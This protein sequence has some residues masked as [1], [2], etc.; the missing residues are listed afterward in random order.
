ME[1]IQVGSDMAMPTLSYVAK[2]GLAVVIG[3]IISGISML[4]VHRKR[5]AMIRCGK[6]PNAPH[7]KPAYE[8]ADF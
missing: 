2:L 3:G 7:R 5:M 4:V 6:G 1:I 8:D